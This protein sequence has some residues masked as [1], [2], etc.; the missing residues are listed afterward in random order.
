MNSSI[1]NNAVYDLTPYY[2]ST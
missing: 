1:L 2:I